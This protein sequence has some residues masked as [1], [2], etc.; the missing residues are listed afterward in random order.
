[1]SVQMGNAPPTS[2]LR[3]SR[4][5]CSQVFPFFFAALVYYYTEHKLKNEEQ[6]MEEAWERGYKL[7]SHQSAKTIIEQLHTSVLH[8]LL[9][10]CH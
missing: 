4:D 8:S 9:G 6:K 7:S 5:R 10:Q 2:T 3:H 1:M